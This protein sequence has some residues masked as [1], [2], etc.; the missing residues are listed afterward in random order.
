VRFNPFRLAAV[1][2]KKAIGEERWNSLSFVE[3]SD[4]IYCE[5]RL[6]DAELAGGRSV[7]ER[8]AA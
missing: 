4:A 8:I 3:Q 2:A 7:P 6:V 5:L 1:R